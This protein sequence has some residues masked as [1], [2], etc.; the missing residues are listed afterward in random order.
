MKKNPD[1]LFILSA[2]IIIMI[3]AAIILYL[4]VVFEKSKSTAYKSEVI[5]NLTREEFVE[6]LIKNND[7]LKSQT[8]TLETSLAEKDI[9]IA[10]LKSRL[11]T[12]AMISTSPFSKIDREDIKV[13]PDR[14]II[15]VNKAFPVY[16]SDSRS[17]YPFINENVFA[18][19][20]VPEK[21][22]D[23]KVGDIIGFESETFNTTVIH[24]IIETGTDENGWYAVTKGD[25]NP[26]TD[27]AK[28]RFEDVKGVLIGLIY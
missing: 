7:E 10:H 25:D 24:R 6:D 5:A 13:F 16:F 11:N 19:E 21:T 18:L 8:D 14:V 9:L 23:M 22:D 3:I 1:I 26:A 4:A 28:V 15:Y 2:V 20:I 17:M 27:P 12:T